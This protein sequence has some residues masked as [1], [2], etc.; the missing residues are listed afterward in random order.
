[1]MHS[2]RRLTS[3]RMLAYYK[4]ITYRYFLTLIST[5]CMNVGI[6]LAHALPGA[7]RPTLVRRRAHPLGEPFPPSASPGS[8]WSL[9]ETHVQE[10]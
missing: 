4:S 6:R 5:G 2:H 7:M 1:M 8:R 9:E 3:M 10:Q